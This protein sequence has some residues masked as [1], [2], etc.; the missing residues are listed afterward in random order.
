MLGT[1]LTYVADWSSQWIYNN[2]FKQS[3]GWFTQTDSWSSPWD[4]GQADS[5]P[6]DENGYPLSLPWQGQIVCTLLFRDLEGKYP[7][8][9]YVFLYD[10]EGEITFQ[11][12]AAVISATP[13]RIVLNVTPSNAGIL[14]KVKKSTSGNH[15]RNIRLV[16]LAL[17]DLLESR[18]LNSKFVRMCRAFSVL[19]FMDLQRTNN[20]PVTNTSQ[21]RPHSYCTQTGNMGIAWADI[22]DLCNNVGCDA[23]L[24]VPHQATDEFVTEMATFFRDHL[25]PGHKVWIEYSNEVWNSQFS[26]A[27]YNT[28]LGLAEGLSTNPYEARLRR[29]A[30]RSV[31]IF[32]IF[33]TIV[34]KESLIRVI[35]AQAG[36]SWVAQTILAYANTASKADVLAIAP[37]FGGYLGDPSHGPSTALM[38]VQEVV[39]ACRNN[40]NSEVAGW[41]A[42]H[43]TIANTHNVRLVSYEMGQHLVGVGGQ[44][45]NQV[46]TNLFQ[47]VNRSPQMGDLYR[48]Y[49]LKWREL[50]GEQTCFF[51]FIER[52]SKWGSWGM[53][54]N[55]DAKLRDC[56][57]MMS[58]LWT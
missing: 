19:R 22:A 6:K 9:Q 3:R 48:E 42:A 43:R 23:W 16:P 27:G 14:V 20:S 32:N 36:N 41:I 5:V 4:T 37:Y 10:G 17:E 8:G 56:P 49:L 50:G 34:G 24:C 30:K 31:E 38:S 53:M 51:T 28:N 26:Q 45:N 11:Y 52:Y 15:V 58:I 7:G 57:K 25:N 21:L 29:Y 46:L 40:I 39:D 2:I 55:Q 13:G 47:A 12:D 1:N 18:K 35:A 33:E 54:E 44:E